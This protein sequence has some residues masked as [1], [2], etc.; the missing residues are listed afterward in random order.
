[1]V[2]DYHHPLPS[3]CTTI[4]CGKPKTETMEAQFL[5]FWPNPPP[6]LVLANIQPPISFFHACHLTLSPCTVVLHGTPKTKP[7]TLGFRF[8]AQS[9]PTTLHLQMCSPA[10]TATS[11]CSTHHLIAMPPPKDYTEHPKLSCCAWF[12]GF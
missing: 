2:G 5:G 4:L 7:Q 6:G 1:M 12:Q 10:V 3:S 11:C 8:L 9:L